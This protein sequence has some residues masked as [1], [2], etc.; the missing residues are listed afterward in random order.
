MSVVP[1]FRPS[2]ARLAVDHVG[3]AALARELDRPDTLAIFGFGDTA[4][5]RGQVSDPRY[6][7]VPLQPLHGTACLEVWRSPA[8]VL[9]G[10]VMRRPSR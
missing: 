10:V 9:S 3:V 8:T 5:T 2:S 7:H 4:P 6:L 1:D